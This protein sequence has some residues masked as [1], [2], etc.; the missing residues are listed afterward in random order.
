M[1][2]TLSTASRLIVFVHAYE[3]TTNICTGRMAIVGFGEG[4]ENG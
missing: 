1:N 3:K 4:E 2:K